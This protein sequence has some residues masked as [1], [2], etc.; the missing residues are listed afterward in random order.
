[1]PPVAG[2]G[3]CSGA[4]SGKACNFASIKV[5]VGIVWAYSVPKLVLEYS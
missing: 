1:M 2:I 4:R 5:L 3:D